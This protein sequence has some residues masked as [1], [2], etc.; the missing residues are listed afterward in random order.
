M[1]MSTIVRRIP[2]TIPPRNNFPT[3]TPLIVEYMTMGTLGGKIGPIVVEAAVTAAL[4]SASYPFC[5]IASI[6]ICPS[7]AASEVAVPDIPANNR[8]AKMFA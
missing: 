7:P 5:F 6:S 4:K 8:L 1:I 2:G 3:E